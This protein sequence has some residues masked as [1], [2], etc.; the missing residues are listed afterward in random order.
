M[1]R[2]TME[3]RYQVFVSST[4]AD[5]QVERQEVIQALLELDCIPAGM[6][7]FPA[8]DDDQWT[9]IKNVI[10]DCDYYIVVIGG[11]YGSLSSDGISYTQMEYEYAISQGKPVLG[12]LHKHPGSIPSD[13]TEQSEEGKL[14]LAAFRELVQKRMCKYWSTPSELGSIVS[15][16]LVKLM[17]SKPAVGW[18]RADLLP[19]ES[20]AEEILRLRKRVEELENLLEAARVE[21]PKGTEDLA[22][23]VDPYKIHFIYSVTNKTRPSEPVKKFHRIETT[24]DE[25]FA[26]LSPYM[27]SE[28][29]EADLREKIND[30]INEDVFFVFSAHSDDEETSRP[31]ITDD[32]FN[33]IKVQLYALGLIRKSEGVRDSKNDSPYWTLTPYGEHKMT[34]LTALRRGQGDKSAVPLPPER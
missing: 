6:E 14:K 30:F 11:R 8:A 34:K 16:S 12:F 4:Y 26:H 15:R 33:K 2:R 3:R 9:L 13:N 22:Q 10:D 25:I 1:E 18:V 32:T 28:I 20:A 19:D 27:I 29:S 31:W 7:L 23:G 21:S 5:L 24:W 17:K